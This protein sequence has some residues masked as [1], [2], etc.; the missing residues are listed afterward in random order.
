MKLS[1]LSIG[2]LISYINYYKEML[3]IKDNESTKQLLEQVE[4]EYEF[5]KIQESNRNSKDR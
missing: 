3:R 5:R 2:S 1:H 4:K